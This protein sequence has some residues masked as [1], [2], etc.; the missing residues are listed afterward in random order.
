MTSNVQ[1]TK[2]TDSASGS[3]RAEAGCCTPGGIV[4]HIAPNEQA[5]WGRR[6]IQAFYG[7]HTKEEPGLALRLMALGPRNGSAVFSVEVQ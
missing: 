5:L 7:P 4:A 3:H 2:A 1:Q 6:S